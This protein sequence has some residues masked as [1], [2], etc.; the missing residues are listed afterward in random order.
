MFTT[1]LG[2]IIAATIIYSGIKQ[3]T[4]GK[5]EGSAK[6]YEKYTAESMKKAA[7]VTGFLYF[8][9]AIL[10]VIQ[11]LVWA[12]VIA[13]PIKPDFIYIIGV[14]VVVVLIIA[15]YNMIVKKNDIYAKGNA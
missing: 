13:S 3:I 5:M 4:T 1:V 6:D 8:P 11:N 10:I 9:A 14:G 7:I 2:I 15:V 12:G